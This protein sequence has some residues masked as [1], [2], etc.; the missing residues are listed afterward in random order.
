M[1][2]KAGEVLGANGLS[3]RRLGWGVTAEL[4][5]LLPSLVTFAI[6]PRV[7]GPAK[8][9]QLAALLAL[10]ALVASLATTGA[11]IVYIRRVTE[12]AD[13]AQAAGK[14]FSTS[15]LGGVTGLA[16]AVPVAIAVFDRVGVLP[17][18]LL[19]VAE[20][21]FGNLLHVF[22]GL[23]LA[24]EDQRTLAAI[25]ALL[26]GARAATTVAYACSPLRGSV[27]GFAW[28]YLA[29]VIASSAAWYG[30][31]RAR[32]LW[33]GARLQLPRRSEIAGGLAISS[34]A[35]AFYVQDGL[36][37]PMI[38]HAGFDADAGMYASAYRVASLAF[39]PINAMVLMGLPLLVPTMRR[40]FA[41]TRRTALRLTAVGMAYGSL[42]AVLMVIA[43][44]LLPAV[45][46][47][48]YDPAADML[49][50]LAALPLLRASQYFVANHL[51][52]SGKQHRRLLVQLV[53]AVASVVAYVV[54]IPSFSWR[55][56]VAGTYISEVVLAVGLWM[57]FA[58]DE[59]RRESFEEERLDALVA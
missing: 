35:A 24:R 20:L 53:S 43:A 16:L 34:T 12:G 13:A 42:V 29:A 37:T 50:W 6:V 48:K 31:V 38:V 32:G 56:A 30:V 46:G 52:L 9:G 27:T 57:V 22:S 1:R 5:R 7:L 28:S 19:F 47:H 51:M 25:V 41:A 26:A 15:L 3:R 45:V 58:R 36:D 2:A 55:G 59:Q 49:R 21:I 11:H 17:I 10:L 4:A 54:L 23:A 33:P 18:M 8:Y 14:A 39:A 40:S 44:P